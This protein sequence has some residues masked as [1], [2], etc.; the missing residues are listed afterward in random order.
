MESGEDGMNS[1]IDVMDRGV[2]V[3]DSSGD[4][5][6]SSGATWTAVETDSTAYIQHQQWMKE[7]SIANYGSSTAEAT[8]IDGELS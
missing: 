3:M 1:S 2:E 7:T 4:G 6:D 8:T 5:M